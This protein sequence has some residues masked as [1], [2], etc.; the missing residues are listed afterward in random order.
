[1]SGGF[2]SS[3]PLQTQR[4][5]YYTSI[6]KKQ[7]NF[8][9][10]NYKRYRKKARFKMRESQTIPRR[11][12]PYARLKAFLDNLFPHNYSITI[13]EELYAIKVPRKLT[14]SEI[15]TLQEDEE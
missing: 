14:D 7:N 13:I 11:F 1:M 12:I 2:E 6:T 8:L 15:D 5:N 4:Q 10:S 3:I 9:R